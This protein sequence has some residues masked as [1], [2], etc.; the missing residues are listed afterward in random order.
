MTSLGQRTL[1]G[2]LWTFASETGRKITSFIIGIVL[3]RLLAP[4]H[5]GLVAMLLIFFAVSNTFV[6]SGFSNALIRKDTITEEDKSTTFIINLSVAVFFYVLLWFGA[7]YIARFYDQPQLVPLTRFMGV[8]VVIQ[9]FA[10]IQKALFTQ[11]LKFRQLGIIALAANLIAGITGVTLAYLGYEVWSLAFK[12]VLLILI[13]TCLFWMLQPWFP[14]KGFSRSSFDY[15]FGFGSKLLLAGLLDTFFKNIY[16]VIIGR[17]FTA[18]ILGFYTHAQIYVQTVS[19]GSITTLQKVTYPILSKTKDNPERLKKAYR[20]IIMASSFVIFPSVMGLALIAEPMIL[21]LVGE[22]WLPAVPFLQIFCVSGALYHLHSVNLNILKVV[23][24]SDLFL[25]LEIIKKVNV[26]VAI[27][28][29]LQF[30]IWGLMIAKVISSYVALFINLYYTRHFISYSYS[31]QFKDLVPV[32]I[33]TIPMVLVV[34]VIITITTFSALVTLMLAIGM[35]AIVYLL[36]SII[37]KSEA[38]HVIKNLLGERFLF[39]NKLP[40]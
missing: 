21:T 15:L 33:H 32:L 23:G 37:V 14:K 2:F 20:K 13:Q 30:G 38:L 40:I 8:T 1:S 35:G 31:E 16:K 19:Q 34:Y 18:S 25:R 12:Y 22:Q 7:P 39:L 11:Q 6:N 24:R 9:A 27:I 3:A 29:G 26:T 28:I 10:I 4:E 17:V 5:F 36:T